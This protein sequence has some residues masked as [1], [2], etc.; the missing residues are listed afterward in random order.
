LVLGTTTP[1]FA[2]EP[3]KK[4]ASNDDVLAQLRSDLDESSQA[5]VDAASNLQLAE[6]ALPAAKRTAAQTHG[7]LLAAQR[8]QAAA[9]HRRAS[10]Q[11]QL[12]VAT[13]DS[14]ALAGQVADQHDRL[15]RLAR[16]VYQS[17]GSMS[18]LSMLLESQSPT[19]FAER[20][21]AFQ[22]VLDSQRSALNDLQT[23]ETTYG[24]R[25]DALALV[26]DKMAAADEQAQREVAVI[27][28]LEARA[29]AA[30]TE[31]QRLLT[32]RDAA[33]AATSAAT[34]VD[35]AQGQVQQGSQTS[36]QASLAAQAR[37]LLGTAGA[38]PGSAVA[39][40]PGTLA[41]PAHGPI[42]S[43][44]GMRVHPITG[45]RKLHTGTDL[46]IPCGTQV[47]AA[48]EGTVLSAGWDT[49]YGFRTVVSHGVVNGALLTTTYNHQSHIGVT[50]G[51]HVDVGELIG[52]SGTT[53]YSTGCHLH[54]ELLVNGDFVD[55]MP[56]M[57]GQ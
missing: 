32:A 28:G 49:A 29:Q 25:T 2:D 4:T 18:D 57:T 27:A 45:V 44:F 11:V 26:R 10:A 38:L 36:L 40:V 24:D 47:H 54:F 30:A 9:A 5:M 22:T 14:E 34:A 50:V 43:P 21:V 35:A 51:Q 3:A 41:W 42:T 19:D 39:S 15:G 56:W 53:G 33:V 46:G 48:R 13:Q 37:Q 20:L 55:P 52:L 12:I 6:A 16:A 7:L 1:T 17:G 31:V 23:V 8:R